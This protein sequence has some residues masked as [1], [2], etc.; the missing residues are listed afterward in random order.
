MTDMEKHLITTATASS[1]ADY[2][3]IY[4]KQGLIEARNNYPEFRF[5]GE[6]ERQNRLYMELQYAA[7]MDGQDIPKESLIVITKEVAAM[8]MQGA[9]CGL[10]YP[11]IRT[12]V[13]RGASG[14][15]GD[16]YRI[17]VRTVLGWLDAFIEENK[18]TYRELEKQRDKDRILQAG[19]FYLEKVRR[20]AEE[21]A[22][23]FQE[24]AD[25]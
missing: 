21:I 15:Y 16:W 17:N 18:A 3:T 24:N 14:Q 19:D 13:R 23:K 11:E 7:A 2:P 12:A 4:T 10:T 5:C 6:S 8:M 1:K 22:K 20:H 25:A 9:S